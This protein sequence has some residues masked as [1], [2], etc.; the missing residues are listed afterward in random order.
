MN[1]IPKDE[2]ILSERV[3]ILVKDDNFA[4]IGLAIREHGTALN[5]FDSNGLRSSPMYSPRIGIERFQ[6]S[7]RSSIENGWTVRHFGVPNFG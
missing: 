6:G 3:A 1:E 2:I 5:S 7:L 4:A